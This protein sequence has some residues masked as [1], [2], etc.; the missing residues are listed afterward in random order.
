MDSFQEDS[1]WNL[2]DYSRIIEDTSSND[3]YWCNQS[4]CMELEV[5]PV[6]A[7][8]TEKGCTKKRENINVFNQEQ[9]IKRHLRSSL[10][11]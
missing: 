1:T 3:F 9:N 5:S 7:V 10:S 4:A 11:S 8:L 6:D 2:I